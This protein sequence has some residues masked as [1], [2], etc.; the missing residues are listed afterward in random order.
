MY[1][2]LAIWMAVVNRA[3]ISV[4]LLSFWHGVIEDGRFKR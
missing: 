2:L 3:S 1:A 4:K